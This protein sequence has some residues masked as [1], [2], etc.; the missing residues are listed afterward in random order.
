M[1]N[2]VEDVGEKFIPKAEAVA[3][4]E[5]SGDFRA[6]NNFPVGEG[7][8]IGGGGI[9]EMDAVQAAALAGRD[10]DDAEQSREAPAAGR[11][12]PAQG[13]C[14]LMTKVRQIRWMPSLTVDPPESRI[15]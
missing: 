6:D 5:L 12:Q 7:E 9:A 11:R 15:F 13:R 3:L 10:E 4:A 8:N 14:H 1:E 2:P